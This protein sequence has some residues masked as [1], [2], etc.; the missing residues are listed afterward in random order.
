MAVQQDEIH[1]FASFAVHLIHD[2]AIPALDQGYRELIAHFS[3]NSQLQNVAQQQGI[4]AVLNSDDPDIRELQ[5][6][7]REFV[8]Q[9]EK[10]AEQQMTDAVLQRF[11]QHTIIGEEL[12]SR[13]DGELCWIFDPI[14]GTSAMIR[15]ALAEAFGISLPSPAPAWGVMVGLLDGHDAILGVIA[16]LLPG[17]RGLVVGPTW[18]GGTGIPTTCNGKPLESMAVPKNLADVDMACTAPKIM[19]GHKDRENLARFQALRSATAGCITDQN[20]I[21]FMR[22]LQQNSRIGIGCEADLA[23]PDIAALQPI[24]RGANLTVTDLNG[25]QH[26]FANNRDGEWRILTAPPKLH[27]Q[28]LAVMQQAAEIALAEGDTPES[29]ADAT[30]EAPDQAGYVTKFQ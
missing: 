12:G 24:L 30:T 2:L 21:G 7:N 28:A 29:I 5:K 15:T 20:C 8:T 23:L 6:N 22:I 3:Q 10:V 27:E 16:E 13:G 17:K 11:P 9:A 14:D 18:V 26:N 25:N 1:E 19:F 4:A